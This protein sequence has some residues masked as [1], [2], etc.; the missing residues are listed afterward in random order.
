MEDIPDLPNL[1]LSVF[2]ALLVMFAIIKVF[3]L[4]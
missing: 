4:R 2:L 3:K 1:L